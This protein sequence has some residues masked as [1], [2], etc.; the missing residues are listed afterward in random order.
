M[1][2]TCTVKN[3]VLPAEFGRSALND[4]GINTAEPRNWGAMELRSLAMGG[5]ADSKIH[6]PHNMYYHIK[7]GSYASQGVY[8]N[9][10]EG[11]FKNWALHPCGIGASMTP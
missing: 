2:G 10:L 1:R 9:R 3:P 7:F 4:V 8:I 6:A 11:N 5:V